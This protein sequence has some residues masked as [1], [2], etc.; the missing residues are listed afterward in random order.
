MSW[1][2]SL[3]TSQ[4][5]GVTCRVQGFK[6]PPPPVRHVGEAGLSLVTESSFLGLWRRG[7][8][9]CGYKG[10]V[11][12]DQDLGVSGSSSLIEKVKGV[13]HAPPGAVHWVGAG[14][15]IWAS[16]TSLVGIE[17]RLAGQLGLAALLAHSPSRDMG[18][19]V[20]VDVNSHAGGTG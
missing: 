2:L 14:G 6:A 15:P 17:P 4:L 16:V 7:G 19:Q 11:C 10:G 20:G 9:R 5:W 8:G 12:Q 1:L 3:A 13:Q 18:A